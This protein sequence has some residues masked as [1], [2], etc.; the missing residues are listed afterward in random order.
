MI[1][2]LWFLSQNVPYTLE[3]KEQNYGAKNQQRMIGGERQR[4]VGWSAN[5]EKER[6]KPIK[7]GSGPAEGEGVM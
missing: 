4:L 7:A 2:P 6:N 1:Q 3:T 5:I